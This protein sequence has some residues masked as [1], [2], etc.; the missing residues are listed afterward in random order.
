MCKTLA[1]FFVSMVMA[2]STLLAFGGVVSE[3]IP[4]WPNGAPNEKGDVGE[5]HDTT[6]PGDGLVAGQRVVRLGNVSKPTI[7]LYRPAREKDTGA[8]V[9][10]CPGGGY[11]ILAMDLEG[12]EICEWFNSIG[13][14]GVLL[15]YPCANAPG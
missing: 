7:T 14:T 10:V 11:S 9:V 3:P 6:K 1:P 4:L 8:A 13:V 2:F 15:K 5:E 12:T